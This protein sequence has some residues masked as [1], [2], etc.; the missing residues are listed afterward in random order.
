L[1]KPLDLDELEARLLAAS[2]L[3]RALGAVTAL[4]QHLRTSDPSPS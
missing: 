2:H 1:R 4:W 3:V